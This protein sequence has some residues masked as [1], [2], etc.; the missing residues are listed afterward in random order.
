MNNYFIRV[1]YAANANREAFISDEA[2]CVRKN[3]NSR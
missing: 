2:S 1:F 3:E